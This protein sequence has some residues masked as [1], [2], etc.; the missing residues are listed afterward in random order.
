MESD[1]PLS[2]LKVIE[3]GSLIAGPYCGQLLG[4]LGAEVIKL[5]PPITG[6]AFR[7]WG[8]HAAT[9]EGVWW[10]TLARNKKSVTCNLRTPEGQSIFRDLIQKADV[11]IEN[12]RLGILARWG[13]GPD[14]LIDL[15][16]RLIVAQV[17][18]FGQTGPYAQ[19]AGYASIEEAMAGLRYITG[20]PDLPPVRVGLS[21]GDS[22]AGIFSCI[23]VL[24]ALNERSRSGRGQTIDTSIY[25][26]VLALTVSLLPD[27]HVF[28][29]DR[30]RSGPVLEGIAPSNIYPTQDGQSVVIA[31]NQDTVY[32]QLCGAMGRIGLAGTQRFLTQA[33]RGHNMEEL[34]LI[35]SRGS[36]GFSTDELLNVLNAAGVPAGKINRPADIADPHVQ[37]RGSIAWIDDPSIGSIPMPNVMP[38]LGRTPGKIRTTGPRLGERTTDVLTH[39]LGYD[40]EQIRSLQVGKHI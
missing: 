27:H 12:F 22:M 11:L 33:A 19:R 39:T 38:R 21:L 4:D 34:D 14:A 40:D 25:E 7:T 10:A 31:A 5:E 20:Y 32:R 2:G 37:D 28:G 26:S 36:R 35:I 15:I 13:L 30:E 3:A 6:D 9:G 18:G 8:K 17:S 29:F 16:P 1:G 23:G 24:V